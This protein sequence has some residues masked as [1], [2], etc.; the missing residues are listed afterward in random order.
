MST[1]TISSKGQVVIP[2][3][4]RDSL[5]WSAGTRLDVQE[6]PGGLLLRPVQPDHAVPLAAGLAAIRQRV[7]YA[8]QAVSLEQMEAAVAQEAA[9]RAAKRTVRADGKSSKKA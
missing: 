1:T 8:G 6:A 5:R 9:R 3:P 4:L 7:A 2:K